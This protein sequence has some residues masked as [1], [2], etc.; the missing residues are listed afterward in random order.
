MQNENQLSSKKLKTNDPLP[1]RQGCQDHAG[2]STVSV[3]VNCDFRIF[4]TIQK[5][6][7]GC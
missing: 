4:F 3:I 1:V 7:R 6:K 5:I 2:N